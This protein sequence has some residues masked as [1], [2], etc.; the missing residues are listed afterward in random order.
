MVKYNGKYIHFGNTLYDQYEDS[1]PLQ[2]YKDQNYYTNN[3]VNYNLS[4][5]WFVSRFCMLFSFLIWSQSNGGFYTKNKCFEFLV[6]L[7]FSIVRIVV[8]YYLIYF[9]VP[10]W[11]YF[12]IDTWYLNSN[13]WWQSKDESWF[14]NASIFNALLC[15]FLWAANLFVLQLF[16]FLY[17]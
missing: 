12:L 15:W 9:V 17:L 2:L 5:F 1:T 10:V 3:H 4:Y 8:I 13:N 11:F 16:V 7:F 6:W 14:T